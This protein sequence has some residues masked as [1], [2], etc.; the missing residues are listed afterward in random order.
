M[1]NMKAALQPDLVNVK[2]T[3][4]TM[5]VDVASLKADSQS[6]GKNQRKEY[7]I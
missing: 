3:L 6:R 2:D 4:N 1:E 5:Q 7:L